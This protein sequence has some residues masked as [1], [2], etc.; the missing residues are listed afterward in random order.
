MPAASVMVANAM[1]RSRIARID[2]QSSTKPADG[3]SNATGTPAIG[4][5]TSHSAS[6]AGTCAY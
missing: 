2:A 5:H 3:G 1:P 6:G 4:V